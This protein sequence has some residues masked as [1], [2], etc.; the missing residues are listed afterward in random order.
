MKIVQELIEYI[1][2]CKKILHHIKQHGENLEF[3]TWIY[4]DTIKIND[5]LTLKTPEIYFEVIK[6]NVLLV[7]ETRYRFT[8]HR[9]SEIMQYPKH[10]KLFDKLCAPTIFRA[11]NKKYKEMDKQK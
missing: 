5:T 9:E 3:E 11:C 10:R 8:L 6:Y 7:G 1:S 4:S 2:S